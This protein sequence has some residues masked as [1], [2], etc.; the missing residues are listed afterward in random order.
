MDLA[1]FDFDGTI[2][3][4]GTYPAFVRFAARPGRKVAG[5]VLLAPLILG[6]R[7][8]FVTDRTIRA[9]ISRLAFWRD[10]PDRLREVGERFATDVLPAALR[11]GA[12]ERLAWHK[13]RGDRVVVV[14]AALDVYLEPWC[15]AHHVDVICTR[16]EISD[17]RCTGRYVRGDCCSAEK[18]RRIRERYALD[19]FDTVWGRHPGDGAPVIQADSRGLPAL[20]SG[21][22]AP[23][24]RDLRANGRWPP[25][26]AASRQPSS[27]Q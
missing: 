24:R 19:E 10:D 15:R 20:P 9:A 21:R 11:P 2:T 18:A 25:R 5:G 23:P 16:L 8:G 14:S 7:G 22:R 13:A 3:T 1:L 17:G 26:S 4:H 27:G 6:Y 12:L